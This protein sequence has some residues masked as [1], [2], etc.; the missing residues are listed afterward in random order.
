MLSVLIRWIGWDVEL[1]RSDSEI[2]NSQDETIQI[3]SFGEKVPV[4]GKTEEIRCLGQRVKFD[5]YGLTKDGQAVCVDAYCLTVAE[6][7]QTY[8]TLMQ[9][10]D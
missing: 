1:S 3:K 9:D 8:V 10:R 7:P 4:D 6:I 2:K 5:R